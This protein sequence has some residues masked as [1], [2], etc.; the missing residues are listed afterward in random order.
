MYLLWM[1]AGEHEEDARNQALGMALLTAGLL[2]PL[3]EGW[4]R[5]TEERPVGTMDDEAKI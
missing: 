5:L 3:H 2:F 1:L 4:R